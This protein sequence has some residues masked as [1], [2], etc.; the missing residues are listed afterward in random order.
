MDGV[1]IVMNIPFN[2]AN[3]F[4]AAQI[5]GNYDITLIK[6][7]PELLIPKCRNYYDKDG[8][9]VLFTDKG[10]LER[11]MERL[12][13]KAVRLIALAIGTAHLH[14]DRVPDGLT[15]VG[16]MAIRDDVRPEAK[17]AID[18]LL[19]SGIQTVMITGDRKETAVAVAK[20]AGLLSDA[21]QVVLTSKELSEISDQ[22]L[23]QILPNIRVIAR[24]LP[25]DKSRLVRIAQEMNLVVGMTGDGVNDAPALKCADVGF[26]MGSG[27]EVAKEAGDI[28]VLDDNFFSI[29]NAV[30]YGRTIYKSIKK[31]I[32]FQLTI[33]VAAVTI[34]ILGPIVG[35]EKPLDISQMIWTNLMIDSL[36]AI[37]FGGEPALQ[38]YL[39][40]KPKQREEDILDKSMWSSITW[41]GL[42]ISALSLL[43]FISP[44]IH[45]CFRPD[46]GDIFFYTGY[47][48]FFIFICIFNAFN[49]RTDNIDLLKNISLNK[50]FLIVMAGIGITQIFMTYYGGAI[51]RTA[52]LT[53]SEWILV[54]GLALTIIPLDILRKFLVKK[55]KKKYQI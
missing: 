47:F 9:E 37:A 39:N 10:R 23:K 28:V 26:A 15:L 1:D 3:K 55:R 43:M 24:A 21:N 31:F 46:S 7:A 53:V 16:V 12:A 19:R 18:E 38:S 54:L 29:R 35:V 36:A 40:E 6:G 42:Y 14:G 34:S 33:N 13:K 30:L 20:D 27:S 5:T 8:N 52:G 25:T 49:A 51:L 32:R 45:S 22:R 2:S 17:R 48:T 44:Q 50:Q 11:E 4:S 41:D